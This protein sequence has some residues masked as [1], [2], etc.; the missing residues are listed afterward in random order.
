MVGRLTAIRE[1]EYLLLTHSAAVDERGISHLQCA[2]KPD[3]HAGVQESDF[4]RPAPSR[5]LLATV[6]GPQTTTGADRR[7]PWRG[8]VHPG[9]RTR[10]FVLTEEHVRIPEDTK[11]FAINMSNMRHWDTPVRY[12]D[13]A[14]A[15]GTAAGQG[16]QH[17]LD[18]RGGRC[19]RILTR[20]GVSVPMEQTRPDKYR[21]AAPDVRRLPHELADRAS[22]AAL[23]TTR[24]HLD[25]QPGKLHEARERSPR[26]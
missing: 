2:E 25:I 4:Y 1:D 26:L 9:P 19:H 17:A 23:P 22:T 6:Y 16:L 13:E 5:L 12:I 14:L 11:E 20:G 7:R 8:H 15:G 18:C 3:S 10:A 21:Q 24:R